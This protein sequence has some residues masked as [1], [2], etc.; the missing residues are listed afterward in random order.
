[1]LDNRK[2]IIDE[3]G[4]IADTDSVLYVSSAATVDGV[5]KTFDTGGGYTEGM[6][7]IDISQ[8]AYASA[9][10]YHKGID[11][12]LQG[13]NTAAGAFTE[14]VPLAK[15][16]CDGTAATAT[17][18]GTDANGIPLRGNISGTTLG[19]IDT[20]RYLIPFHND[21]KGTVYRYLRIYTKFYG[22][23]SATGG[24]NITFKAYLSKR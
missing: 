12:I 7:A 24:T 13:S 10:S 18:A 14:Y 23:A 20:G 17:D 16:G 19:S 4:L 9:A 21:F 8:V 22:T 2:V 11:I 6:L 3:E 1:M 15:L 5:A